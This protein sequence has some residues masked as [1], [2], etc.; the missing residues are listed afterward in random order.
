MEKRLRDLK[1][2]LLKTELEKCDEDSCEN[3]TELRPRPPQRCA[4]KVY[5]LRH[6]PK[7]T[8]TLRKSFEPVKNQTLTSGIS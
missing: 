5:I 3:K 7:G 1:V 2:A 4:N 6:T 8:H